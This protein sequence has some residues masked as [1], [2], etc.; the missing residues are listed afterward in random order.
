MD[1]L[2][3]GYPDL[4]GFLENES[5]IDCIKDCF[6]CNERRC[7][8]QYDFKEELFKEKRFETVELEK[9]KKEEDPIKKLLLGREADKKH[10][11][12]HVENCKLAKAIYC[13]LW[14]WHGD[15]TQWPFRLNA[16]VMNSFKTTYN[17]YQKIKIENGENEL[18]YSQLVMFAKMTHT[19][20]NFTI[21]PF[22]VE[23]EPGD[24]L[25]SFN[26]HRGT[27]KGPIQDYWDISLQVLKCFFE[28]K[29]P[30]AGFFKEYADTFF[31]TKESL[32]IEPYIDDNYN[33]IPL[34]TRKSGSICPQ[35]SPQP[36]SP[37]E[38]NEFL[39]NVNTRILS[40]SKIMVKKLRKKYKLYCD[41]LF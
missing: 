21:I 29:Y 24:G 17:A 36:E 26:F 34:F 28:R 30:G 33:I 22:Y 5:D 25:K 20:G 15:V 19:I 35:P 38:M 3:N 31:H 1:K 4:N 12:W 40:R 11:L 18:D 16:D 37:K 32:N 41:S 39:I 8:V 13:V 27:N 14:G 7:P 9:I 2:F 10:K 23:F 6:S